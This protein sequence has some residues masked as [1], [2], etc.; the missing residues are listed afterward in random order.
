ME[1]QLAPQDAAPGI[2]GLFSPRTLRMASDARLVALVRARNRMAFEVIHERY[3]PQ[4]LSFC[5][6]LLGDREE[7]ADAVQHTFL[8]AYD[9]IVSSERPILLRAWLF[10]IARNRCFTM[11]RRRRERPADELIEPATEGL[12]TQVQRREELRHLLDDMRALPSE[13]RI[14]LVLA[15]LGTM[16]HQE[17]S[18][19]L[20]VPPAKVKALVFQARESLLASRA[21]RDTDCG[22]IRRELETAQG[23]A[24]RRANL[25]RHLR[26]CPGCRDF[27]TE[28]DLRRHRLGELVPDGPV[29]IEDKRLRV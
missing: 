16:S 21:A 26:Q 27:R 13:Q 8:A 28:V 6:H 11:L 20:E 23:G 5:R 2:G 19:A 17:I 12:A 29:L 22:D 4:L 7:A 18:A 14:A 9:A 1:V 24:L 3:H 25:R 15:E 10:T